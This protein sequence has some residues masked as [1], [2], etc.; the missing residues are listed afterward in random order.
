MKRLVMALVLSAV[1]AC[2]GESNLPNPSGKGTVRA[3]NA[4]TASPLVGFRIEERLLGTAGVQNVTG[5]TR[6]DDFDYIFNFEAA[7]LGESTARTVASQALKIDVGMDYTFVL[8]GDITAPDVTIWEGSER[9][10]D[11]SETVA[12]VR[13]GNVAPLLSAGGP[14][15]VFFAPV[16]TAPVAGEQIATLDFGDVMQAIDMEAIEYVITVTR[17]GDP[18]LTPLYQS[19]P[20][21]YVE[22]TAII[23]PLFDGDE[24]GTAAVI[25]RVINTTGPS[26]VLND[27]NAQPTIR[28]VQASFDLA[29]SDV[30]DDEMLTNQVLGDHAFGEITDDMPVAEGQTSYYYTPVGDTSAVLFESGIFT[31]SNSHWNWVVIGDAGARFALT[32]SPLRRP[33]STYA[34]IA[35]LHVAL[36]HARLDFY[37]VDAGVPIDDVNP[38]LFGMIYSLPS[39]SLAFVAGSY[40]MYLTT[41]DEKTIVAGPINV[42]VV[43][44]DIV[45]VM[46]FDNVDPAIADIRILPPQ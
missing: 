26:I 15:D 39:P 41:P 45:E 3:I 2:S 44:G 27:S 29:N 21:T 11:G 22:Q 31:V 19:T 37:V 10:W 4:V 5:A 13:F 28:F 18:M 42:D 23:I 7:F 32:Y 30:Y 12:E 17:A 24:A 25:A 40:D 6:W 38:V 1:V 16:G 46:F 34:Q 8:T 43:D 36:N 9:T 35:P 20:A 14:V 33:V